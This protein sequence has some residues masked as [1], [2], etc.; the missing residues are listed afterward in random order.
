MR[1]ALVL[2]AFALFGACALAGDHDFFLGKWKIV[3]ADVAPWARAGA[4]PDD[5][6][7]KM[8]LGKSV[9]FEAGKIKGPGILACP[10]LRYEIVQAPPEGLFQGAFEEMQRAD[11]SVSPQKL[12]MKLGF[13]PGGITTLQTGCANELDFHFKSDK[14]AA[15]ALNNYIYTIDKR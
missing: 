11:K 8:L 1:R 2:A 9:E 3:A 4:P 7:S 13:K 14:S 12:A 5:A 10:A 6:E 15:F